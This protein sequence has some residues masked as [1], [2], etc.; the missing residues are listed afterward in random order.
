MRNA[1]IENR[2]SILILLGNGTGATEAD[3][4]TTWFGLQCVLPVLPWKRKT[5]KTPLL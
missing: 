2:K 5:L 3:V 4:M 1:K